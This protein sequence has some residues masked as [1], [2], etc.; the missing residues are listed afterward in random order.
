M[1]LGL[2]VISNAMFRLSTLFLVFSI[3]GGLFAMSASA[4]SGGDYFK[5]PIYK[6][7]G[8]P[9]AWVQATR[10]KIWPKPALEK[11]VFGRFS[12]VDATRF[13][14]QLSAD[15]SECTILRSAIDRYYPRTFPQ[16]STTPFDAQNPWHKKLKSEEDLYRGIIDKV[17]IVMNNPRGCK[18]KFPTL[19]MDESYEIKID[20]LDSPH[21]AQIIS[22][23]AWGALR[24]LESFSQ[25]VYIAEHH[26]GQYQINSTQI[27]DHPRF[28]HRGVMLDS[29]R[30]YL[31]KRVILDNLDL[32]EMN[33]F[34]VFHWHLTDN[35]AFPYE[36][37][38]FPNMSLKGAYRPHTHVYSQE[39]VRDIIEYARIRGIRIVAEFDVPGKRYWLLTGGDRTTIAEK[40]VAQS[41]ENIHLP[42]RQLPKTTITQKRQLHKNV[43]SRKF[44]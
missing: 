28:T 25:L 16:R 41:P 30:H 11:E 23:T 33:K 42:E 34:N 39:V 17:N 43:F 3:S 22:F 1:L 21:V 20:T 10:G 2:K 15:A 40:T 35:P 24:G 37:M 19:D 29:S 13:N 4:D 5:A 31:S 7:P 18:D 32:M 12:I 36:S 8:R 44:V 26:G 6:N 38:T 14:F 27:L 9:G